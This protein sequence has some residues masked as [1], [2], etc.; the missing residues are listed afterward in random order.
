MYRS[1]N[2]FLRLATILL[3]TV[4][5]A[6]CMAIPAPQFGPGPPP[7]LTPKKAHTLGAAPVTGPAV[8]FA[9]ATVT[10]VPAELRFLLEDDLK[11]YATTRQ[12]A[13]VPMGDPTAT[14]QVKGYLSAV[15]GTS[16]TL[17]VYIWDVA[18]L[19][20][21]PLHRISGQETAGG[22]EADPWAGITSV[23]ID[24]AARETVD[25]LA[26]WIRG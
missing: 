6:G 19:S 15:G 1:T 20:G 22:S 11:R 9:F 24:E 10:G 8:R 16:G 25:K 2:S 4:T 13:I 17:L 7:M 26:D 23:E 12:L 18:N 5:I 14:Y 21:T 3:A